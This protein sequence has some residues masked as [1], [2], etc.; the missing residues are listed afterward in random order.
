MSFTEHQA[1]IAAR[2]VGLLAGGM[3]V[4]E[5]ADEVGYS[6]TYCYAILRAAGRGVMPRP[7]A[8]RPAQVAAAFAELGSMSAVARSMKMGRQTV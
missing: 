8:D 2:L 7:S 6:W 4:Y 5:A 3:T 1:A